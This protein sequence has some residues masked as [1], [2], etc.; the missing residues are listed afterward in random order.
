MDNFISKRVTLALGVILNDAK[1]IIY[2]FY[3]IFS[4]FKTT[5]SYTFVASFLTERH[6]G[7]G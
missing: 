6:G 4:F 5:V 2:N 3:H 7:E 1:K